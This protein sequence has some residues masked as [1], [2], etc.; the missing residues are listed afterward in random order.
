MKAMNTAIVH[1]ETHITLIQ[2]C[3]P[4]VDNDTVESLMDHYEEPDFFFKG[5][6]F[7]F[8]LCVPFWTVI[9]WFIT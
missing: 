2:E 1:E 5:A 3:E 8:I 7:G 4:S 9:F 6:I